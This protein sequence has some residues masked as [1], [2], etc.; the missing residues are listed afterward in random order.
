VVTDSGDVHR[1]FMGCILFTAITITP[2]WTAQVIGNW[3]VLIDKH[4]V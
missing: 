2:G 1:D 4:Y 3:L